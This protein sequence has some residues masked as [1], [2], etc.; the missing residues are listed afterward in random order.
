MKPSESP[1]L[2]LYNGARE[3][4]AGGR[5]LPDLT[6]DEAVRRCAIGTAALPP[7]PVVPPGATDIERHW[8]FK[9]STRPF[10]FSFGG[11]MRPLPTML[12]G[13]MLP[14]FA[15][16]MRDRHLTPGSWTKA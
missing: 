1:T 7:D 2:S 4:I 5:L 6:R 10:Y 11:E 12:P 14:V 16:D 8:I 3:W 13:E 9:G 15:D